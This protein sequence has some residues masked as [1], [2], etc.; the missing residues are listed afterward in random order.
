MASIAS[1]ALLKFG[2]N[3]PSSPTAV[4]RPLA[5]RTFLREWKISAPMRTASRILR[6]PLGTIMNSCMSMGASECA[7][8]L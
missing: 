3:P 4:D 2:A 5:F 1:S 7:P 8:R 6:A